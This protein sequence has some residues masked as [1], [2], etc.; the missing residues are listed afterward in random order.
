MNDPKSVLEALD[1]S[2][3]QNC[4]PSTWLS[5]LYSQLCQALLNK[6]LFYASV[7]SK[8]GFIQPL[9]SCIIKNCNTVQP[10]TSLPENKFDSSEKCI[11]T[12]KS[13]NRIEKA[14]HNFKHSSR[15]P[16]ASLIE[17]EGTMW[18]S[19]Q[20]G[21][22]IRAGPIPWAGERPYWA[23]THFLWLRKPAVL[24]TWTSA[25]EE[26]LFSPHDTCSNEY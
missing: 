2:N 12:F 11:V 6:S 5:V 18:C 16:N 23:W 24:F 22:C 20:Q 4:L 26:R 17:R 1:K 13:C 21:S 25:L 9:K 15:N 10:M 14:S 8:E 19:I 7:S 3:L